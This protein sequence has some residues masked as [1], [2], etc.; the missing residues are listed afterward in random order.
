MPTDRR[1]HVIRRSAFMFAVVAVCSFLGWVSH[2]HRLTEANIVMIFL[3]G[4]AV[5]AA[6][7][8]RGPAI[9]AAIISVLV[10]DFFFVDPPFSFVM[11]DTQY[12]IT[13]AVMLGI[14]LLINAL[15]SKLHVQLHSAEA[16]ER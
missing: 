11:S 8:G 9:A 7:C 15:T 1:V 2:A 6:R 4:V 13:L 3:A 10:F 16:R 5:V 12:F 14:G